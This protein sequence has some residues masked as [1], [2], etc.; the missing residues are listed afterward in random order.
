MKNKLK[1]LLIGT[2]CMA[3]AFTAVPAG[4]TPLTTT[5]VEA[6]TEKSGLYHEGN[7]WNYYVNNKI[8]TDTTT[9]VK[10]NGSWWYVN[11][12]KVDF[13]ARTLIK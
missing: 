13:S 2:M 5:T 10:Y 7:V 9:L 12:G 11:N 3:M 4:I 8:A 1:N 6:A